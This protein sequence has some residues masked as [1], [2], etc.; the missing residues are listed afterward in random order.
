MA[1]EAGKVD[2]AMRIVSAQVA[3]S[4]SHPLGIDQFQIRDT[5]RIH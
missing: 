3:V 1:M 4:V 5:P 2:E